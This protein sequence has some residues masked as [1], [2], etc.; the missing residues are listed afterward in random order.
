MFAETKRTCDPCWVCVVWVFLRCVFSPVVSYSW[1]FLAIKS[2]RVHDVLE[3]VHPF[4]CIVHM[5]SQV[6]V[7]E[8]ERVSIK[9]QAYRHAPFVTL[10]DKQEERITHCERDVVWV[11]AI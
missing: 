6:A 5:S 11:L 1:S 2:L 10:R 4:I 9:R 3:L 7:E 8:A